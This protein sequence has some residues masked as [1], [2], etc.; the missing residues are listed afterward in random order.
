MP[1]QR[2]ACSEL[3]CAIP[4]CRRLAVGI[5]LLVRSGTVCWNQ[6]MR[7]GPQGPDIRLVTGLSA[8]LPVDG[9][10]EYS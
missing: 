10:S 2:A 9:R 6:R 1:W 4:F 5:H 8:G 3:K 7:P